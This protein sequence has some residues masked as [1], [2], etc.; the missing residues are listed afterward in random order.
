MNRPVDQRSQDAFYLAKA[1]R[2]EAL[3]R[4]YGAAVAAS[5]AACLLTKWTFLLFG[6]AA[7]FEFFHM[8]VVFS[9]FWGGLGP[10][11]LAAVLC[12]FILDY[13]FV[14]PLNAFALGS[15]WWRL[16]LFE[17]LAGLVSF[18]SWKLKK[19]KA[20]IEQAH[21]EL[22]VRIEQRTR[23][24]SRTN[25]R[26]LEEIAH[27]K[28][29]ERAILDVSAREQRRLG[30]DLHDGL[31]QSIAG[32]RLMVENVLEKEAA[33]PRQEDLRRIESKLGDALDQAYDVSRGLYPVELENDGL[34]SALEELAAKTSRVYAADCRF[35]CRE[36][37]D[38]ANAA[39][40]NHLYRI[41]QEAVVNAVKGGKARRIN[42]SLQCRGPQLLLRVADNG[43]GLGNVPARKGMGMKIME[44]RA[45]M[46]EA[47]LSFRSRR[48]GGTLVSCL[49]PALPTPKKEDG[50]AA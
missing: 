20:E 40:A 29:A 46:I 15:H 30:H 1:A 21:D 45:Q 23:E 10:G 38:V 41:A 26:L 25:G 31:C 44:Y 14:P 12:F 34:M 3:V 7:F 5:L 37:M 17:G 43:I 33:G 8:A 9:A 19:A 11:M 49:F 22:E 32:V 16:L 4:G 42:V 28:E 27:R 35:R 47:G 6:G 39:A 36:P 24:L 50:G 13:F 2:L 18:L 48:K